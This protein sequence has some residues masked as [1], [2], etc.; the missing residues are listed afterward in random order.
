MR[1]KAY[2]SDENAVTEDTKLYLERAKLV[3]KDTENC[4]LGF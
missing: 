1:G 4:G 2:K 3:L